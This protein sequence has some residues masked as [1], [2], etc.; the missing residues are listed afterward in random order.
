[1]ELAE[2]WGWWLVL[3]CGTY[4]IKPSICDMV[5]EMMERE[6]F[7]LIS[8][9]FSLF[10]GVPTLILNN[11]RVPEVSLIGILFTVNGILRLLFAK[12]LSRKF[13]F[14]RKYKQIPLSI[15]ALGLIF[16]LWLLLHY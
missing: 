6:E 2:I 10:L 8:A 14:Y 4:L 11:W 1:M 7:L 9:W 5:L 12:K 15:S 3:I 16:G 13:S